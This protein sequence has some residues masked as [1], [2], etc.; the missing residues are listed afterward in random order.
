MSPPQDSMAEPAH[1]LLEFLMQRCGLAGEPLGHAVTRLMVQLLEAVP[2]HLDAGEY[3]EV[4]LN[5]RSYI[6]LELVE[7]DDEITVH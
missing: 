4:L 1:R 5:I 2:T 3:M 7:M 6:A